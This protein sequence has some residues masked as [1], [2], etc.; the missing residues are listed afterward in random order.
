MTSPH[1]RQK[2]YKNRLSCPL[3]ER[4]SSFGVAMQLQTVT[5][6]LASIAS[7]GGFVEIPRVVNGVGKWR[8]NARVP[9]VDHRIPL[10]RLAANPQRSVGLCAVLAPSDTPVGEWDATFFSPAKINLFLRILGKRPDG[11]HD[12]ASLFQVTDHVPSYTQTVRVFLLTPCV[13]L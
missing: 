7:V 4:L 1:N 5:I 11:F 6:V 8:P 13:L 12:L 2:R 3:P 9:D 10:S